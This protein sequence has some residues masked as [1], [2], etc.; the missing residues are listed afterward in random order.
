MRVNSSDDHIRLEHG[1]GGE[2][3]WRLLRDVIFP[4]LGPHTSQGLDAALLDLDIPPGSKL[5]F[6]TDGFVVQPLHFPG[7]DIGKLSVCG[8]TNDLAMMGAHP[9]AL[10]VGMI[11]EEGL[12]VQILEDILRSIEREAR[13]LGVRVVAGDTKVVRKGEADGVFITTAGVGVCSN[14]WNLHPDRICEGDSILVT[15]T[16]GDHGAAILA[17]RE[18]FGL[19]GDLISDCASLWPLVE[20]L[21]EFAGSIRFMRDPTRGGL[22]AVLH[23]AVCGSSL[24]VELI[25]SR[26]PVRPEVA[27]F[28]E[29]L[30]IDPLYLACEGRILLVVCSEDSDRILQR[31]AENPLGEHAAGIGRIIKRHEAAVVMENPY[32]SVR[33]IENLASE[34][35]PR[36]C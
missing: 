21:E 33:S 28:S 3:S 20:S 22:A 32:G 16:I 13:H 25:E 36:I 19:E 17:A 14:R 29:I 35:L 26:L 11:L 2:S 27:G 15:G 7:G 23:E 5:G 12:S 18:S 30:G 31:I 9:V 24:G 34:Q 1:S 6:T 8:T 10:T 4:I